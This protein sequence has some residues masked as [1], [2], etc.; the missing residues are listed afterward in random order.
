MPDNTDKKD[1]KVPA[2]AIDDTLESA[3]AMQKYQLSPIPSL[4]KNTNDAY[5]EYRIKGSVSHLSEAIKTEYIEYF[6]MIDTLKL[7]LQNAKVLDTAVEADTI[8]ES[9]APKEHKKGKRK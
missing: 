1:K 3:R 6:G 7:S 9:I 5:L 2:R 8:K 4:P